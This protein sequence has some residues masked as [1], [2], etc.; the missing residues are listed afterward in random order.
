MSEEVTNKKVEEDRKVEKKPVGRPAKKSISP[1]A[2]SKDGVFKLEG[3]HEDEGYWALV[4]ASDDAPA[5]GRF[6]VSDEQLQ[7]LFGE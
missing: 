2:I 7:E 6:R 3:P 5:Y 1:G 4:P